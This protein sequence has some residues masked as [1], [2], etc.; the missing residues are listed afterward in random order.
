MAKIL[1]FLRVGF[2][3][4]LF[5][6]LTIALHFI[7]VHNNKDILSL[8]IITGLILAPIL[9]TIICTYML[10]IRIFK[11]QKLNLIPRWLYISNIVFWLLQI[12]YITLPI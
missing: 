10:W 5:F 6:A 12:A 2:I 4:N 9:N 1:F 3:C 7:P 8:S 11:H